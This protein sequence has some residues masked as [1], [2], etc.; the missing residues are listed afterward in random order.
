MRS[1]DR[2][3]RR[4]EVGA[5]IAEMPIAYAI[6]AV[7]KGLDVYDGR[8]EILMRK[9]FLAYLVRFDRIHEV[10]L[11]DGRI[12]AVPTDE[13]FRPDRLW[14]RPFRPSMKFYNPPGVEVYRPVRRIESGQVDPET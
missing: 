7:A 5:A 10:P 12:V 6:E 14:E 1:R 4:A 11:S 13:H 8:I 9:G 3:H 2:Q